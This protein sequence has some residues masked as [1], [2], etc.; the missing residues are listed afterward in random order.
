[1]AARLLA[2]SSLLTRPMGRR[3]MTSAAR[4]GSG[5]AKTR[6]GGMVAAG[7]AA[8]LFSSQVARAEPAQTVV[9]TPS[10]LQYWEIAE[11]T[12]ECPVKGDIVQVH[13][14]GTLLDS[15]KKFDSSLDRGDPLQFAVGTGR[16][17]KG[18]DEGIMSMKVGGKRKLIIPPA[19][20]YGSRGAGGAIP[21]NATLVFTVELISFEKKAPGIF[22]SI[23]G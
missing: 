7:A 4:L 1:M 18:W 23:F 2:R 5:M 15:G 13:Y 21:P 22:S 8:A 16:V 9:N 17:I 6:V 3:V 20:G 19:L 12:G 10:G 11:G 14:T